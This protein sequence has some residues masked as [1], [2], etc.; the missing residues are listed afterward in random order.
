[1][2]SAN[3]VI[4]FGVGLLSIGVLGYVFYQIYRQ[5]FREQVVSNVV[6]TGSQKQDVKTRVS[7]GDFAPI[8]GTDYYFAPISSEQN[9]RQ[10]YYD[11]TA[12]SVRNYL[13]L[14]SKDKSVN[15]L[16]S[17]NH[18]LLINL[19]K[20]GQR[21]GK[22]TLVKVEGLLYQIVETDTN[23]DSRLTESD[24]KTIGLS[25]VSGKNYRSLIQGVDRVLGSFQTSGATLMLLY[26]SSVERKNFVAEIDIVNREVV[27]TQELPSI[28]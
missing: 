27:S 13:F 24:Q 4:F 14:N 26:S 20:L 23:R 18:W 17:N 19:E 28:D 22:G 7:L 9:Y 12:A 6:N 11:K 1:L 8:E 2:K 5:S 15:R 21:D 3:V 16:L 10:D 25:N